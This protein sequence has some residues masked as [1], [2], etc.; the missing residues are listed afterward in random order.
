M[1]DIRGLMIH[2]RLDYV[3]NLPEKKQYQRVLQ[4]LSEGVRQNIGEQVF[5]TNLYPFHILKEVD[6]AIGEILNEPLESIFRDIGKRSASLIM[7]QYFFNYVQAQNP[8][9]F[10]SQ[11][12]KLY[13]SL[14]N[15][16]Q[17]FYQKS[18]QQSARLKFVYDEDIH[19]PF[20]WFIQTFLQTGIEICGGKNVILKEIQCEADNGE[21][22][23]Y[24]ISWNK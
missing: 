1:G 12:E 3:E 16:G 21:S 2:S 11:I 14:C 5:L 20:C 15:L 8:Q 10:L 4:H 24:E 22:C 18:D 17:Y 7:E 9:G 23:M 13:P 6:L 19:K